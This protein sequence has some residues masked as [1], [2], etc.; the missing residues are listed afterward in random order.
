MTEV[1]QWVGDC[2]HVVAAAIFALTPGT[3]FW[4]V[5]IG[6]VVITHRWSRTGLSDRMGQDPKESE[7]SYPDG[8]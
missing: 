8:V 3:V 1:L 2:F 7:T 5:V 6:I 4:L